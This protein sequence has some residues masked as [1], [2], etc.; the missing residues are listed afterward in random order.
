M[1]KNIQRVSKVPQK[2]SHG[3][4]L[5]GLFIGLVIG[6]GCAFGIAWYLKKSPLPFVDKVAS[7]DKGDPAHGATTGAPPAS[8][9]TGS[10][11]ALPG[12]P[13]ERPVGSASEKPR[14]EF[15]KI[16]PGGQEPAPGTKPSDGRDGRNMP[17][18]ERMPVDESAPPPAPVS[19]SF[20]LQAGSFQKS[21]DA[22]N[23]KAKLALMGLD[24][25]VQEANVPEK[26]V[27]YR[28]RVGPFSKP[29][30]MNRAR[31]QLS[32]SGIQ[33]SVVKI[34]DKPAPAQQ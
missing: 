33:A 18:D 1:S 31:N 5:I 25:S 24:T 28:V 4:T 27:V 19:S 11:A 12:K 29:E 2:K 16:L 10:P 13:G 14:F 20:Y 9:G 32:Q 15:Y 3:G 30:E 21:V 7:A 17:D 8:S 23:L 34:K 6:L 22:D 26:G